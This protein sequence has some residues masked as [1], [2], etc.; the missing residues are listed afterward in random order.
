MILRQNIK[1]SDQV[2]ID[3]NLK[4]CSAMRG[5]C[6]LFL[7]GHQNSS[8]LNQLIQGVNY[9]NRVRPVM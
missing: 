9:R 8:K 7:K 3:G 6:F 2:I 5:W 1:Y 4:L